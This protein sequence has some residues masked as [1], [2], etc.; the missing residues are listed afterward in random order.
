MIS[1]DA[2]THVLCTLILTLQV[3]TFAIILKHEKKIVRLETDIYEDPKNPLKKSIVGR[4]AEIQR[5]LECME[6]K[7]EEVRDL[8]QQLQSRM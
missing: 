1:M 6:R 3:T 5:R 8:V 2:I 4:L 7:I